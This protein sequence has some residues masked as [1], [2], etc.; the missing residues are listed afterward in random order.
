MREAVASV[1]AQ[2]FTDW[3]LIIVD[4]ASTDGSWEWL[5][6]LKNSKVNPVTLSRHSERSAARNRGLQEANGEFVVFLD[7]DDLLMPDAL[8]LLTGAIL[9]R[10]EIVAVA[11]ARLAFDAT[12]NQ[13]RILH[14][15]RRSVRYIWR[16][17]VSG[18]AVIPGQLLLNT[19]YLRQVNGWNEN[20]NWAEDHELLF[21]IGMI[22]P[23]AI[24]PEV[25]LKNRVHEGQWQNPAG[26][27]IYDALLIRLIEQLPHSERQKGIKTN[28][29]RLHLQKGNSSYSTQDY[30]QAYKAYCAA[31]RTDPWLITL[32]LMRFTLMAAILRALGGAMLPKTVGKYL[33]FLKRKIRYQLRRMPGAA[34][35]VVEGVGE[36]NRNNRIN[37][38]E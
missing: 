21:R 32:S 35:P 1:S 8:Q 7:D 31:V 5:S 26:R 27:E 24:I 18:W 15:R 12:G 19:N 36:I 9:K 30:R 23:V 2:T 38:T 6:K 14:P 25:V 37:S 20:I 11:G 16:D 10:P 28:S 29:A 13:R 3:E 4:D 33:L 17:V 22:G 34:V